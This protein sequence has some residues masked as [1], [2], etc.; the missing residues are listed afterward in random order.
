MV[1]MGCQTLNWKWRNMYSWEMAASC[2][3]E[4]VRVKHGYTQDYCYC[5]ANIHVFQ[6]LEENEYAFV[7]NNASSCLRERG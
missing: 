3:H 4:E 6:W 1:T 2:F 7:F 5:N